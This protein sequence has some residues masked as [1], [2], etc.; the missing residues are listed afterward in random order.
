MATVALANGAN[1]RV[2]GLDEAVV[3]DLLA[4]AEAVRDEGDDALVVIDDLAAWASAI[5]EHVPRVTAAE[6]LSLRAA[7]V[8]RAGALERG[9]VSVLAADGRS[10][11]TATSPLHPAC[12]VE[13][14]VPL[15]GARPAIPAI[16][17]K[18]VPVAALRGLVP[19]GGVIRAGLAQ[20][21]AVSERAKGLSRLERATR[22]VLEHG[23]RLVRFLEQPPGVPVPPEDLVLLAQV[24]ASPIIDRIPTTDLPA[25]DVALLERARRQGVRI[26]P[27]R[28][29][30]DDEVRNVRRL[31]EEIAA[32]FA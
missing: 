7:V 19:A 6:V 30:N 1:I 16:T 2:D 29:P 8:D 27:N 28:R 17:S 10:G 31:A 3:G 23:A 9:S 18:L 12:F 25:F 22:E 21:V 32:D 24:Y 4:M 14:V 20:W 26:D 11:D 15:E 5:R 13:H